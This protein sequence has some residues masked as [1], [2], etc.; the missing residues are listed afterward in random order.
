MARPEEPDRFAP[1]GAS[2]RSRLLLL[3]GP[4]VVSFWLR[5]TFAWAD[6]IF[7]SLLRDADGNP[8]G[9]ASIAAIG[10]TLP[11]EFLQVA[12]WVGTSN[13]LTARLAEAIGAG[14]G[15][16]VA[17]L[18]RATL[19]ILAALIALFVVLA[20]V[21]WVVTPRVPLDPLVAQQFRIY[22][23]VLL[24]G[25]ALTSFWSILPDSLVKAHHDTRST[26]WAG[27]LSSVTN[28]ALNAFFVFVIGLGILGI[29]LSTVLG[30]L[31]GLAYASARAAAHERR[32]RAQPDQ[33]RPGR[34]DRPVRSILAIAV[35]SGATYVLMALE[36]QFVNALLALRPDSTALLASWAVFDRGLRFLAMPLIAAS[37]AMLPLAAR[38]RG[39]G[40]LDQVEREL[41]VGLRAG[42]A[43]AFLFAAPV[44]W[45]LAGPVARALTDAEATRLNTMEALRWMP[46]AVAGLGPFLLARATWD[47][48]AR[49][50][51]GLVAAMLRTALVLPLIALGLHFHD[52][53][54]MA[55]VE[56]AC[57]GFVLAVVL[58]S[59]G[60]W[61][62]TRTTLPRLE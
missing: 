56:G 50:R 2:R 36:S 57:L 13:G 3:A 61:R 22:A 59:A 46:L 24:A 16:Q 12:L 41:G 26:M 34:F 42:L 32:R 29:A 51:V 39:E 48:L 11:F 1:A 47:G 30:R 38:L 53:F 15:E 49:P 20:A 58:A 7:A 35:P 27:L 54:G 17:Q 33:Q 10:L 40:R 6:T 45:L 37:V 14:R 60:M 28:V 43:Y 19:R 55:P 31:A 44:T 25:G 62:F 52:R 5:S 18:K 21:V 23:V 8:I 9:D 4:L